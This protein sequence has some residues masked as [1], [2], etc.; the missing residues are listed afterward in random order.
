MGSAMGKTDVTT[1]H[2]LRGLPRPI[3]RRA[4]PRRA[5]E[6]AGPLDPSLERPRQRAMANGRG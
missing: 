5:L 2:L 4:F 6:L 3:L 1:R